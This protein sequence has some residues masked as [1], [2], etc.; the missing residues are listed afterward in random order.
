MPRPNAPSS[1]LAGLLL[2]GG[3]LATPA[4]AAMTSS[5]SLVPIYQFDSDLDAGGEAGYAGVLASFGRLWSLDSRSAL[6]LRLNFDYQ[7]WRFDDLAG[8][9]G[10]DPWGQV[11]RVGLSV[12]Y[13][14]TTDGGWRWGLTPTV[15]YA[16][17][18]G[19]RFS[20]ALE[21]GANLTAARAVRP[22]LTLGLGVGVYYRI[23]ETSAFPFILVDWRISDR[24]RLSNPSPAGPSGP[25]GLEL[26][27]RL[28]SGWELGIGAAYRS[29]RFR[30]DRDGPFPGGVGEHRAVPVLASLGRELSEGLSLRLYAGVALAS[31]LR[32][33]DEDGRRLYDEDRDPAAMVGLMVSGRF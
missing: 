6:G 18:S 23:E 9:G 17:E 5:Y 15:E 31:N 10:A 32:V 33:E 3:C 14:V 8:F 4:L 16:G 11:Y 25:A 13:T 24:L 12:P 19:A 28:D 1:R 21:Y 29:D 7:D 27:Y 26:R 20:D 30:L 22:D 2:A